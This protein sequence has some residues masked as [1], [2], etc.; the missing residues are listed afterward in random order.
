M[1]EPVKHGQRSYFG[2]FAAA[3]YFF[4]AEVRQDAKNGNAG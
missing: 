4:L 2:H 1:H 3:A